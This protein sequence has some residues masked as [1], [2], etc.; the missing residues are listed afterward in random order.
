MLGYLLYFF[1][2]DDLSAKKDSH[3][4]QVVKAGKRMTIPVPMPGFR[5]A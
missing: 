5:R 3:G 1:D 2:V 4:N